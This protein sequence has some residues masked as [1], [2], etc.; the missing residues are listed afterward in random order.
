MANPNVSLS[1]GLT[2]R[3]FLVAPKE[4]ARVKPEQ[5]EWCGRSAHTHPNP[6][7]RHPGESRDPALSIVNVEPKLDRGLRRGDAK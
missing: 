6:K 3:S 7:A 5:G 1:P 2:R 4:V